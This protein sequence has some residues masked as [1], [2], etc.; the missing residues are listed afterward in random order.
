[1]RPSGAQRILEQK[2]E[3]LGYFAVAGMDPEQS[4]PGVLR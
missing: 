1:M 3:I 4:A 2:G